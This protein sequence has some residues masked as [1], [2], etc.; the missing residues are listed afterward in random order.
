MSGPVGRYSCE[1]VFRRLDDYVD[2]ELSLSEMHL[3][4]EHLAACAQC[5]AEYRFE[6]RVLQDLRTK[7]RRIK[8]P[9]GLAEKVAKVIAKVGKGEQGR[10]E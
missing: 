4:R 9:E 2:R 1:D 5:A 7:L 6:A 3:V 10:A 8:V